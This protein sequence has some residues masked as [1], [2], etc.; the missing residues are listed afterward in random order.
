M[1]GL[2]FIGHFFFGNFL[3]GVGFQNFEYG[4]YTHRLIRNLIPNYI[5]LTDYVV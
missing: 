5:R 1:P 4:G 3:G 2:V